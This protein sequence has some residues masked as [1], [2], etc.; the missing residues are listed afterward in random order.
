MVDH[1][2]GR[3]SDAHGVLSR[4][5][6]SAGRLPGRPDAQVVLEAGRAGAQLT[7]AGPTVGRSTTRAEVAA[8]DAVPR[9]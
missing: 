5:L 9:R 7:G 3:K 2:T 8:E 1:R 4:K 6:W